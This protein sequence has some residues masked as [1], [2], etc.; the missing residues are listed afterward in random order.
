MPEDAPPYVRV[1]DLKHY[2]YCPRIIYFDRVLGVGE[3]R[4]SQQ[5]SSLRD[6]ERIEQLERRRKGVFPIQKS[7]RKQLN[8]SESIYSPIG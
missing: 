5:L 8:S 2:L 3:M 6:H 1:V 4:S 7:W